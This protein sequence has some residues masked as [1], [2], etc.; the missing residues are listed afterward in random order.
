L[1]FGSQ[2]NISLFEFDSGLISPSKKW[3]TSKI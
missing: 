3:V 2:I 1:N